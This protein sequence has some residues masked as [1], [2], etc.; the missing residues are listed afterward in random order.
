M[1]EGRRMGW[2]S[3]GWWV[4]S[5][6]RSRESSLEVRIS[7]R[8]IAGGHLAWLAFW[9][10]LRMALLVEVGWDDGACVADGTLAWTVDLES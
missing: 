7:L 5:V 3:G 1:D 6:L 10:L 9:W 8:T 4:C 2:E